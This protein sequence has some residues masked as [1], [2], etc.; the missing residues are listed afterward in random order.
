MA[1]VPAIAHTHC[2]LCL[3]GLNWQHQKVRLEG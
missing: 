2:L 3:C 1:A